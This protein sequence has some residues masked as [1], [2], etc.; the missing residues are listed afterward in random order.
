[1]NSRRAAG[2]SVLPGIERAM[3][4]ATPV[5]LCHPEIFTAVRHMVCQY[6]QYP[7]KSYYL[8]IRH[9]TICEKEAGSDRIG[10]YQPLTPA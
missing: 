4:A 1:M 10:Q 7:E 2:F 5:T 3:I 9:R 6:G 8:V